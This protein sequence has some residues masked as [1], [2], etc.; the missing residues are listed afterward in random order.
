LHNNPQRCGTSVTPAAG[1]FNKKNIWDMALPMFGVK[2]S[3][4]FFPGSSIWHYF[5]T[6]WFQ[7]QYSDDK[8]RHYK[9]NNVG[10]IPTFQPTHLILTILLFLNVFLKCLIEYWTSIQLINIA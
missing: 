3:F 4:H 8:Y 5:N 1:P 2:S 9:N 7:F 10:K 6:F